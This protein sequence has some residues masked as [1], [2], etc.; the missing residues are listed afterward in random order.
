[1][2]QTRSATVNAVARAA[3]LIAAVAFSTLAVAPV[4]AA[5]PMMKTQAPVLAA[6]CLS[7]WSTGRS[8]LPSYSAVTSKSPRLIR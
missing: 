5:A 8:K 7:S 4:Q 3:T 2:S 6:G 1:M